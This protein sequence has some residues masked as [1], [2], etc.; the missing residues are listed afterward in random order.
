M[1]ALAAGKARTGEALGNPA[2]CMEG[3]VALIDVAG[4]LA[5]YVLVCY[6]VREACGILTDHTDPP[7]F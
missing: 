7:R 2:L 1:F 6:A 4:P 3:L 5:G